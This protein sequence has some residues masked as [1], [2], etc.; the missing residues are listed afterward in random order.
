MPLG[1]LVS[2]PQLSERRSGRMLYSSD[3]QINPNL[4][5]DTHTPMTRTSITG[6]FIDPNQDRF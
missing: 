3:M 5:V 6:W 2:D 1:K 4:A